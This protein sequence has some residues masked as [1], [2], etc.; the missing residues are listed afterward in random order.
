MAM[1]DGHMW[2]EMM[3]EEQAGPMPGFR[4]L[5]T[6]VNCLTP[7]FH[8]GNFLL[9]RAWLKLYFTALNIDIDTE[10]YYNCLAS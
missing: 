6:S 4:P 1:T 10:K 2:M 7:R 5:K 9:C 3:N 8:A